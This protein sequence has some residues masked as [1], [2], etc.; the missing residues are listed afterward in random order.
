M[1]YISDMECH[2]SGKT[3][4]DTVMK[5]HVDTW[6]KRLEALSDPTVQFCC[7]FLVVIDIIFNK[8]AIECMQ[9]F[10]N[11]Q[12]QKLTSAYA[13]S[14][15]KVISKVCLSI[16]NNIEFHRRKMDFYT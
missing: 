14:V 3:N 1:K 5:C 15:S 2:C 9:W 16:Q 8:E 10:S 7:S 11:A 13:D 12:I 4:F 6:V